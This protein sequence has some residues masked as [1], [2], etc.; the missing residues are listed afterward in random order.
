ML[1]FIPFCIVNFD[2]YMM[3]VYMDFLLIFI[4]DFTLSFPIILYS[5]FPKNQHFH[6]D[7]PFDFGTI[8]FY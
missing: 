6:M 1:V 3:L 4:L 7:F 8:L 5:L 2:V